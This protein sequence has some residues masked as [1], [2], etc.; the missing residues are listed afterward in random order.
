MFRCPNDLNSE[1]ELS[2]LFRL[3]LLV[4][5]GKPALDQLSSLYRY[6]GNY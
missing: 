3:A 5:D 2:F 4:A 1:L 6:V